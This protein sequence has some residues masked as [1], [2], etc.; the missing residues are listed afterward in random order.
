MLET[1]INPAIAM[2]VP[3][4]TTP[5][6]T[7]SLLRTLVSWVKHASVPP[8]NTRR[9]SPGSIPKVPKMKFLRGM[10]VRLMARLKVTKG[11]TE[12]R[13]TRKTSSRP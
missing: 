7:I 9:A 1:I 12:Q 10:V 11:I 2:L 3:I 6:T 5:S 4:I 8:M 13:R